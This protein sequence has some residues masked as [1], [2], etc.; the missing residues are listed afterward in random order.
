M[1]PMQ[2]RTANLLRPEGQRDSFGVA[3][4]REQ[5]LSAYASI[6]RHLDGRSWACGDA[7]SMR[8]FDLHA[9]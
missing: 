4:A 8:F 3:Q 6:D 5:L 1:T 7:F 2:V 9:D